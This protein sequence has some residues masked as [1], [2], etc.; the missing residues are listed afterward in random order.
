MEQ[1]PWK[2]WTGEQELPRERF[3]EVC[4][5][6]IG[7]IDR[8]R[9]YLQMHLEASGDEYVRQALE[10]IECETVLL[11]RTL[12]EMMTLLRLRADSAPQLA[13]LDLCELVGRIAELGGEIQRQTG[14]RLAADCGGL[15][16]CYVRANADE[17][18]GLVLHLLS[19]AL[20]ACGRDGRI[21]LTLR[22]EGDEG[23]LTVADNGC[24]LPNRDNWLENR[25]RF[26]GGAQAGLLLCREYCRRAGWELTLENR[27]KRGAQATIRMPLCPDP[28]PVR[29]DAQLRQADG[30]G[31]ERLRWQLRRELYL[32]VQNR[33]ART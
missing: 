11:E 22:R 5:H 32:L 21:E 14:I 16:A 26:L 12:D 27:P 17:V 7:L 20:R 6:A 31:D 2:D 3:E 23:V 13:Y 25:R 8:N 33:P 4:T 9:E 28:L 19:N 10:D 30:S 1:M 29:A 24:G 15:D 18:R